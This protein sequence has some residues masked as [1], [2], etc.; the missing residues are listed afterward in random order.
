MDLGGIA[1]RKRVSSQSNLLISM[2]C[3][4][5]MFSPLVTKPGQCPSTLPLKNKKQK[6]KIN[7]AKNKIQWMEYETMTS[8]TRCN[9]P[10]TKTPI[11]K[12]YISQLSLHP[13]PKHFPHTTSYVYMTWIGSHPGNTPNFKRII[14]IG[15]LET[16]SKPDLLNC[17]ISLS[18]C[19]GKGGF[20][21]HVWVI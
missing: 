13:M 7:E 14:P 20:D 16:F 15:H 9:S 1:K 12:I 3:L 5:I 11:G 4:W 19:L 17:I 8:M 2:K 10:S 6:I 18:I 21:A